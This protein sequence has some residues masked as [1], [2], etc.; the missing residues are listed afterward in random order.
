MKLVEGTRYRQ[1]LDQPSSHKTRAKKFVDCRICGVTSDSEDE[2]ARRRLSKKQVN[3][4]LRLDQVYAIGIGST[5]VTAQDRK[6]QD[7]GAT[8]LA[9]FGFTNLMGSLGRR[10]SSYRYCYR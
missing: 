7:I 10:C 4:G 1:R 5:T 6:S 9:N 8:T 2:C 3:Q